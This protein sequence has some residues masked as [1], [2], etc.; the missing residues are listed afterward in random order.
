MKSTRGGQFHL[1]TYRAIYYWN[2]AGGGLTLAL[3]FNY[4]KGGIECYYYT[5]YGKKLCAALSL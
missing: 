4:S 2:V 5:D 3:F 1:E